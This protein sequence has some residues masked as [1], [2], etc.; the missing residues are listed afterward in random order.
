MAFDFKKK[1][2][3]ILGVVNE[4]AVSMDIADLY[5]AEINRNAFCIIE[6]D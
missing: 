6:L 5:L 3:H 4:C 2:L 1:M